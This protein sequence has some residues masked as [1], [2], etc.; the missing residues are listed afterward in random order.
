MYGI[1]H[2]VIDRLTGKEVYRSRVGSSRDTARKAENYC[3][4]NGLGDRYTIVKINTM[5]VK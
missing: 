4:K 3:R 1:R 5:E 2:T